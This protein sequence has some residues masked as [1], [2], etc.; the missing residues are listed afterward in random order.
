D[1]LATHA[2]QQIALTPDAPALVDVGVPDRRPTAL[3]HALRALIGL[4]SVD[5]DPTL[6]QPEISPPLRESLRAIADALEEVLP[7][8]ADTLVHHD[9]HDANL[10]V[11]GATVRVADWGECG[12]GHPWSVLTVALRA[13]CHRWRTHQ[14]DPRVVRLRDAY[15]LP[16]E[17][18]T[19]PGLRGRLLHD[20]DLRGR[21][22]RA[23]DWLAI[24]RSVTDEER[25]ADSDAVVG[26]LEEAAALGAPPRRSRMPGSR[27][28][29]E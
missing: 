12:I 11:E 27:R 29:R 17:G 25:R 24:L 2:H 15:L 8:P 10:F 20:A 22:S 18:A 3:A 4:A 19:D 16:W 7:G 14:G 6:W 13:A 23:F 1:G 5:I 9:L 26:W 21:V 28:Q